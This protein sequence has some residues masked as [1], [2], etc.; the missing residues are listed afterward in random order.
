MRDWFVILLSFVVLTWLGICL[1]G[2]YSDYCRR[3]D[4]TDILQSSHGDPSNS[5]G[6]NQR[7][8]RGTW[9]SDV[10][11]RRDYMAGPATTFGC[12]WLSVRYPGAMGEQIFS[13]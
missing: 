6:V 10:E 11:R 3:A 12:N 2:F 1:V 4:K 9:T 8:A 7:W 5:F 13:D